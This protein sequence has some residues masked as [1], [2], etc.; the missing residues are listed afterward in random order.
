MRLTK[1]YTTDEVNLFSDTDSEWET[2]SE[3]SFQSSEE[4]CTENSGKEEKR[5]VLHPTESAYAVRY[6]DFDPFA[7]RP[8]I[9]NGYVSADNNECRAV[10]VH[11]SSTFNQDITSVDYLNTLFVAHGDNM[12]G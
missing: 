12:E 6:P 4:P 8:L 11:N 9:D 5:I 2:D 7:G 1:R 3:S 10:I